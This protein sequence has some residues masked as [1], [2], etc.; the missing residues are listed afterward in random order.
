MLISTSILS[1]KNRIEAIKVLNQTNT[2][3]IHFDIMDN[4]FVPNKS[5][6]IDEI[7]EYASVCNKKIDAHFMVKDPLEYLYKLENIKFEYVIFHI[8]IENIDKVI[9]Y[10]KQQNTKI[11]LAIKPNTNL[12]QL[13]KYLDDID[14]ILVM[15]VEPG[16]GGQKF[17]EKTPHRIKEIRQKIKNK[18]ILLEVDG[19]INNETI[20]LVDVDIAVAGSYITNNN[21]YQHQLNKLKEKTED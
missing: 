20:K 12:N 4:I 5:F 3:F 13:D 9:K 8:E 16:F 11:G 15:S 1:T 2:D 18:N 10:L 19:G 14:L 17:I 21:D 6:S 7:K